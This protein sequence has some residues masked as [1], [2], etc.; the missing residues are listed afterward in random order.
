MF[1]GEGRATQ[2][3]LP[4]D[5][6]EFG[7]LHIPHEMLGIAHAMLAHANQSEFD[8]SHAVFPC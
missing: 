4:T 2:L 6:I 8:G 3:V 7:V 1:A 5:G